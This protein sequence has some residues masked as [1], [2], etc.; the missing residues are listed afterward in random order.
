M[1]V[2]DF[3]TSF[4]S[5]HCSGLK[6][7]TSPAIFVVYCAGS[8]LVIGPTPERPATR[9][10]H[11]GSLPMPSGEIIPS[12]V[13]TTRRLVMLSVGWC[14]G[15]L[16]PVV[17]RLKPVPTRLCRLGARFDIRDGVLR[18]EERRVGKEWRA[19]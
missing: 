16:Q 4:F 2:S 6:P 18:S 17:C 19:R 5:I 7:C 12:P 10:S 11:V 14:S 1:K 13:T 8:N 3:L 15:R 9:P